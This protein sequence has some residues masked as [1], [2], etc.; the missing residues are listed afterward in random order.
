MIP[1]PIQPYFTHLSISDYVDTVYIQQDTFTNTK[2]EAGQVFLEFNDFSQIAYFK[3]SLDGGSSW[4]SLNLSPPYIYYVGV[5]TTTDTLSSPLTPEVILSSSSTSTT[6]YS[7]PPLRVPPT[8][9]GFPNV[10]TTI[11]AS[12]SGT[13]HLGSFIN[14]KDTLV[15]SLPVFNP[16]SYRIVYLYYICDE[17]ESQVYI[18]Y[19]PG[20]IQPQVDYI[21]D[22]LTG[23][24]EIPYNSN[25]QVGQTIKIAYA[26]T[27]ITKV[28][29]EL[30]T[31]F[32]SGGSYTLGNLLE[33]N[34]ALEG[35]PSGCSINASFSSTYDPTLPG[36][37]TVFVVIDRE[38]IKLSISVGGTPLID[39]SKNPVVELNFYNHLDKIRASH[40]VPVWSGSNLYD[41]VKYKRH[42]IISSVLENY[43][44][45]HYLEYD[46]NSPQPVVVS[47]SSEVVFNPLQRN[48]YLD[49]LHLD[50]SKFCKRMYNLP[51]VEGSLS[52]VKG[53][54]LDNGIVKPLKEE[55]LLESSAT[56]YLPS[57]YSGWL[58]TPKPKTEVHFLSP[59]GVAWGFIT[60]TAFRDIEYIISGLKQIVNYAKKK[61]WLV[62]TTI[63]KYQINPEVPFGFDVT[64]NP[65]VVFPSNG[66]KEVGPNAFLGYALC[67]ALAQVTDS[68]PFGKYTLTGQWEEFKDELLT[69]LECLAIFCALSIS[70]ATGWAAYKEEVG[71]YTYDLPSHT[72][73]YYTSIFL[74]YFLSFRYNSFI[75][76]AVS[77]LD[78]S[79]FLS[80]ENLTD[81]IY[82]TFIERDFQYHLYEYEPSFLIDSTTNLISIKEYLLLVSLAAR[83]FWSSIKEDYA[84]AMILLDI[85]SVTRTALLVTYPA[86]S[87]YLYTD[88][89]LALALHIIQSQGNSLLSLYKGSIVTLNSLNQYYYPDWLFSHFDLM[90]ISSYGGYVD[91]YMPFWSELIPLPAP[92]LPIDK[93]L[94]QLATTALISELVNPTLP[95]PFNISPFT[96]SAQVKY[97]LLES[98]R[99][100]PFGSNWF[101]R[102]VVE[103]SSSVIGS[104]LA[105]EAELFHTWHLALKVTEDSLS[106]GT[107]SSEYLAKW[108]A[109]LWQTNQ[110]VV[111]STGFLRKLVNAQLSASVKSL[112]DYSLYIQQFI[113]TT[114]LITCPTVPL[115]CSLLTLTFTQDDPSM[116]TDEV[117]VLDLSKETVALSDLEYY[118]IAYKRVNSAW[119]LREVPGFPVKVIPSGMSATTISDYLASPTR[120]A[121]VQDGE[122]YIYPLRDFLLQFNIDIGNTHLV[123]L[124]RLSKSVLPA[125]FL[126]NYQASL[127]SVGTFSLYAV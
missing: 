28:G 39:E 15:C 108:A 31:S 100:M 80:S 57:P 77:I 50:T 2:N 56:L 53:A 91:Y 102:E 74:S 19:I 45:Y 124:G 81:P 54:P 79:L 70:P 98:R 82:S 78:E 85:Y 41:L 121:L 94:D 73:S 72:A 23:T 97:N 8:L 88:S 112:A 5:N 115:F 123:N 6:Y 90:F 12:F 120:G 68:L 114:P 32:T 52:Y 99:M 55:E 67:L 107:A 14:H 49:V 104:M 113:G 60:A 110:S 61:R 34:L 44:E 21:Y 20:A 127:P 83:I 76:T 47:N 29:E 126:I 125:G 66:V 30:Y 65:L 11:S 22:D 122:M 89:I 64:F 119:V 27:P 96:G 36:G 17:I 4:H 48:I 51:N 103:D 16:S 75:H 118:A 1:Q 62:P 58:A 42:R 10:Q 9:Q 33:Y 109:S 59:E 93:W 38:G 86:L 117:N 71:Y 46:Q 7:F 69:T 87:T 35:D 43:S 84:Q 101:A 24:I 40:L 105:A 26:D 18:R 116:Y 25:I 111:A 63:G 3:Y 95:N 106:L 37:D 13:L 92:T